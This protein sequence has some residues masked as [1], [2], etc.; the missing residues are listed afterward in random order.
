MGFLEMSHRD[1]NGPVQATMAETQD[2]VRKLLAVPDNYH[3]LF[4]HGG[5]HAQFAGVPMNL[6]IKQR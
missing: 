4:A 3:V 2:K 6:D 1:A 5:A